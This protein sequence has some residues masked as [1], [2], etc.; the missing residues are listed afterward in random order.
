MGDCELTQVVIL[1][2]SGDLTARKLVPGLFASYREGALPGGVQ[3]VG[4]AEAGEAAAHDQDVRLLSGEVVHQLLDQI[5]RQ[6]RVPRP[7]PTPS[8]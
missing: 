7:R 2:A 4:A 8:R 1:G 5:V 6:C 3:V